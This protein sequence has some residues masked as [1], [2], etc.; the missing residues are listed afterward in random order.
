MDKN[1]YIKH[2]IYLK[3]ATSVKPAVYNLKI[4][5]RRQI[6][7]SFVLSCFFRTSYMTFDGSNK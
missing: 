2:W 6:W 3:G 1:V 4:S 7:L 5:Y